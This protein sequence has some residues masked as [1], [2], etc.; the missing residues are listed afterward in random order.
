MG[1]E[2]EIAMFKD[3]YLQRKFD[4]TAHLSRTYAQV[5]T[6]HSSKENLFLGLYDDGLLKFDTRTN[7][8]TRID[9]GQDYVDV[10]ALY[11]DRNGKLWI[12]MEYGLA[13]YEKES[14]A[15]KKKLITR[16]QT[17]RSTASCTTGK[18]SYG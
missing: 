16:Y 4:L 15:G 7:R 12:G 5:F 8:I 9:L 11:E 3:G 6:I 13:S 1:S 18:A 10:N 2:N 14:F 17:C